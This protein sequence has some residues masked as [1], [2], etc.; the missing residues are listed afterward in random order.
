MKITNSVCPFAMICLQNIDLTLMGIPLA[1]NKRG[2]GS[3]LVSMTW[4]NLFLLDKV[5]N[6]FFHVTKISN[7]TKG[8]CFISLFYSE[9]ERC[10]NEGTSFNES[11]RNLREFSRFAQPPVLFSCIHLCSISVPFVCC[12]RLDSYLDPNSLWI[13]F[14][15][16]E[17]ASLPHIIRQSTITQQRRNT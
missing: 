7:A 16:I 12:F 13:T 11:F 17:S 14:W 8:C 1:M 6:L 4:N 5:W 3:I 9:V 2:L 15:K 10:V